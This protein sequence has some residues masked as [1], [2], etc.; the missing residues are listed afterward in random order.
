ML[1]ANLSGFS[2]VN[3]TQMVFFK[4]GTL[5]LFPSI[6]AMAV[7]SSMLSGDRVSYFRTMS[8]AVMLVVITSL[9]IIMQLPEAI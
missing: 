5:Y 4:L 8:E 6:A 3:F 1:L 7:G 2:V 9:L